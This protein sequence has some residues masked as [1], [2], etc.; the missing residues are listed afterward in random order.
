MYGNKKIQP[1]KTVQN[2]PAKTNQNQVY[3]RQKNDEKRTMYGMYGK[4]VRNKIRYVKE[5]DVN[6]LW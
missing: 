2:E 3:S 5:L 1:A 6:E 4:S